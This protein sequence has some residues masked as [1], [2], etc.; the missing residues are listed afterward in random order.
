MEKIKKIFL[1]FLLQLFLQIKAANNLLVLNN[2]VQNN[3]SNFS[4]INLFV[5]QHIKENSVEFIKQLK[6]SG[7]KKITVIGKPYSVNDNALKNMN[8]YAEIIIPT[9]I[10][11]ENLVIIDRVLK[12]VIQNKNEKFMCLDLGGY[13][14]K[15]FESKKISP[16]NCL[17]IVEDT[18]NGIWFDPNKY[19]PRVPLL[20]VASS[21]IKDYIEH[22]FVAKAIVRNSENILINEFQ[23]TLVAKNI[24]IC[25]YGRI[26]EKIA[27]IVKKDGN[28][29]IHDINPLKLLKASID[30]FKIFNQKNDFEKIDIVIGITGNIVFKQELAKFKDKVIL[31]NGSTRQKEYDFEFIKD[32]IETK[33]ELKNYTVYNLKNNKNIYLL[34][35]GFPVNFWNTESTPEFCLDAVFS[36][37]Y[38]LLQEL[39]IQKLNLG[40]YPSEL[41]FL[42][43]EKEVA[44][45]WLN[46]YLDIK[47][48][49]EQQI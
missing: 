43:K 12:K 7:F 42:D 44:N 13:F 17:G 11:L 46:K 36:T 25:G 21:L 29:F 16:T 8:E 2:L 18:M 34:A 41:F 40:Y 32:D 9:N 39:L 24:L 14:S 23:Q 33:Q 31:I 20:S 4:D 47:N 22:Y 48:N 37:M 10:E 35:N 28:I 1:L 15:Y 27:S 3:K 45:I 6:N 19:I 49:Y 30:G 38:K 5:I 26:G